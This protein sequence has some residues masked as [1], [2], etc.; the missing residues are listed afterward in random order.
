[1]R[2]IKSKFIKADVFCYVVQRCFDIEKNVKIIMISA[3]NLSIFVIFHS[4]DIFILFF[5]KH[6]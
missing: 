2:V 4:D 6:E 3:I 1:M 5:I